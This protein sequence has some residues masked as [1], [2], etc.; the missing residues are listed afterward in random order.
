MTWPILLSATPTVTASPDYSDGDNIGGLISITLPPFTR[1][2]YVSYCSILSKAAI[3]VAVDLLVYSSNP[4]VS[5]FTDNDAQSLH[6]SD[7]TKLLDAVRFADTD[8]RAAGTPVVQG[9]RNLNIPI[10][11]VARIAYFSLVARGT[12]N[13]ASTSD[14]TV[15]FG[16][17]G[18]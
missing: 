15:N 1:P 9:T 4:S 17:I 5:T 6:A 8:W 3:T 7:V 18:G 14:I 11:P 10:A 16:F 2:F 12:I 13:L